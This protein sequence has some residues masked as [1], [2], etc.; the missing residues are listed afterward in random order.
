ETPM[1]TISAP[2]QREQ[3]QR[4]IPLG[5]VGLPEDIAEAAVYLASDAAR[6]VT[7]AI[8]AVDGGSHLA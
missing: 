5:R 2:E 7:G 8:L 1:V 4:R 6:Q 3:L